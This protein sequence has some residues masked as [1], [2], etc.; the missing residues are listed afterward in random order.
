MKKTAKGGEP[1][2]ALLDILATSL[3]KVIWVRAATVG[4]SNFSLLGSSHNF[5]G[6][7][8]LG[9]GCKSQ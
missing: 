2:F 8:D 9:Y 3:V 6:Q 7:G 4:D 1:D 5:T